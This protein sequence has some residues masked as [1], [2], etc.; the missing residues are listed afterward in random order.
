MTIPADAWA[1]LTA[2]EVRATA[3][4]R[5]ELHY[6]HQDALAVERGKWRLSEHLCRFSV[7]GG[8]V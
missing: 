4:D 6:E 5:L 1:G 3:M 8:A 7:P 2:E